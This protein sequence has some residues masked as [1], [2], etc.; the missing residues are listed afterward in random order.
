MAT[1]NSQ[2]QSAPA[3]KNRPKN[4]GV[5]KNADAFS[6]GKGIN[7]IL[8]DK[9]G[10]K[11]GAEK[12]IVSHLI[13]SVFVGVALVAL[14]YGGL[15]IYGYFTEQQLASTLQERQDLDNSIAT[16]ELHRAQ[17][18]QFQNTLENVKTLLDNHIHWTH[19][20]TI[21]EK[22]TVTDIT[23]VSVV[24]SPEGKIRI[25]GIAKDFT[26]LAR[27]L[28]AFEDAKD[29]FASVSIPSGHAVLGQT[30]E[31][32]GVNFDASLILKPTILTA[33]TR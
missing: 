4:N 19:F 25:S 7:L 20:F 13:A 24:M 9:E 1:L 11:Q 27:Q 28:R 16:I 15:Y 2:T 14:T 23:Y 10:M 33:L 5:K 6:F 29:V 12:S 30:G 22:N 18:V 8:Q 26:T 31:T 21:L 17:L 32:I 3:E